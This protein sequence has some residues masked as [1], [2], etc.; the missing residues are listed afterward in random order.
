[1]FDPDGSTGRI[2][3]CDDSMWLLLHELAHAWAH[4]GLSDDERD[5]FVALVEMPSWNDKDDPYRQRAT[6]IA[7]NVIAFG[8]AEGELDGGY[9]RTAKDQI[10]RYVALTGQA[11]PRLAM[12]HMPATGVSG[13]DLYARVGERWRWLG[14]GRPTTFPTNS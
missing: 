9:A 3:L 13:V 5:A 12:P 1:M 11:P 6:E 14:N 8:L 10:E 4:I 2:D 7:A